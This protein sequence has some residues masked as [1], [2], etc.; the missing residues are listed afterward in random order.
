MLEGSLMETT[1]R[2]AVSQSQAKVPLGY[3][4]IVPVGV[5]T[6]DNLCPIWMSCIRW[7]IMGTSLLTKSSA[8][9]R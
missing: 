4:I 9:L 5:T 6:W 3:Y 7:I 2:Q 8:F 1:R